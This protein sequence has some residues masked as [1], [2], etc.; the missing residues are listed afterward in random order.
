MTRLTKLALK[1]VGEGRKFARYAW[2]VTE[3]QK[4]L[5]P[6]PPPP[7]KKRRKGEKF[8]LISKEYGVCDPMTEQIFGVDENQRGA[9]SA[10]TTVFGR[11]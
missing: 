6:P 2:N 1:I 5:P 3:Y 11:I 9:K 4:K 10:P 7:R 8:L